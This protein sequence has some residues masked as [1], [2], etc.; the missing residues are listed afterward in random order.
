MNICELFQKAK[1]ASIGKVNPFLLA[2]LTIVLMVTSPYRVSGQAVSSNFGNV[3]I[4]T[5]SPA[6]PV[7]LTFGSNA[8][9][10]SVLVLTQ[11][12]EGLDFADS[13]SDTCAP[14]ISYS[15]GQS[16]LVNVT[17]TLSRAE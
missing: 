2:A 12:A 14:G 6:V 11:G 3:A 8:T 4:G 13:G 1:P 7:T 10:A 9:L 5:T 15:A 17:F 16:C